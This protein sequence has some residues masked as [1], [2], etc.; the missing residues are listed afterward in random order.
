MSGAARTSESCHLDNKDRI[1]M[2]ELEQD[3]R[4]TLAQ[5][6]D[7]ASLSVSATQARVQ[8]LEKNG[9]IL[10]YK[11]IL[12]DEKSGV[13]VR[14]FISLTPLDY[15]DETSISAL[16][17]DLDGIETC[18]AVS[19]SNSYVLTAH[20]ASHAALEELLATIHIT[21]AVSTETTIVLRRYF[22][23]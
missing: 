15:H 21:A 5:L 4:I 19:G 8:K 9:V 12:D 2:Q 11:A 10:G 18:D 1:I 6:A 16:M 7:A 14:A 17:R 13:P 23:K 3:G 22:V 20:V